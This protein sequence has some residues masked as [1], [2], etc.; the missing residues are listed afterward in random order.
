MYLATFGALCAIIFGATMMLKLPADL[1]DTQEQV[2]RQVYHT[3]VGV[4]LV[5]V[6]LFCYAL[7]LHPLMYANT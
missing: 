6:A 5:G 7:A 3:L 4:V 1:W 2:R